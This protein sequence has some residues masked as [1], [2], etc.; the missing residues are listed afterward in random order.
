MPS[1]P[2]LRRNRVLAALKP[3]LLDAIAASMRRDTFVANQL[4]VDEHAPIS[5]VYFPID[6]VISVVGSMHAGSVA[7]SYT[8]GS[9]GFF[10]V[11]LLLGADRLAQRTT[12]QVPGAFYSIPADEF[13]RLAQ[14]HAEIKR[15]GLVYMHCLMTLTAQ[16]AACN[17]LH[18][19][20][21]RCARWLLLV[22]DRVHS[23]E[24]T[25]TQEILATMLGVHRPAVSIAAGSLQKAGFIRYARG[26]ITV[27]DREGLES[28]S[29]ECYRIVADVFDRYLPQS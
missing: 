12:C 17:L 7:E 16:S 26:R 25:L 13:L 21:A 28:A 11:D 1:L 8:A 15:V 29:C 24:F 2:E 14:T 3:D 27:T 18:D 9:D 23:A 19:V 5:C 20:I 6:G 10:G 22:Q 4:L